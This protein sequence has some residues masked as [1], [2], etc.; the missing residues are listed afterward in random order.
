M[1]KQSTVVA[2]GRREED[3]EGACAGQERKMQI[4]YKMSLWDEIVVALQ[5]IYNTSK[6]SPYLQ[7]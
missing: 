1:P 2:K 4:L 5:I 6:V 3:I 7:V